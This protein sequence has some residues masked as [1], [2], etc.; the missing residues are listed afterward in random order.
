MKLRR[1]ARPRAGSPALRAMPRPARLPGDFLD[2]LA[3][4]LEASEQQARL[5]AERLATLSELHRAAIAAARRLG[6][7]VTVLDIIE[8]ADN[9]PERDRLTALVNRL[10]A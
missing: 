3:Y 9:E 2:E 10:R 1:P 4:E 7:P 8:S 6:R 5:Q